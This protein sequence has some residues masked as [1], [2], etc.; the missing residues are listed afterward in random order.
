[1]VP[2]YLA[3][4]C[5]INEKSMPLFLTRGKSL[6]RKK[7][8]TSSTSTT[9]SATEGCA[10]KYLK[11]LNKKQPNWEEEFLIQFLIF[12]LP[13]RKKTMNTKNPNML[14]I[15]HIQCAFKK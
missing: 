11:C 9:P 10:A 13:Q 4:S 2:C 14:E 15:K 5:K 6:S 8:F 12:Q 7:A 3:K 1:M